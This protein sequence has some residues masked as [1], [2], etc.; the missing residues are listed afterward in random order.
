MFGVQ[1]SYPPTRRSRSPLLM[2]IVAILLFHAYASKGS[3]QAVELHPQ[4]PR[5]VHVVFF[6]G[7]TAKLAWTSAGAPKLE[8]VIEQS[9][10]G[11]IWTKPSFVQFKGTH[12]LIRNLDRSATWFFRVRAIN[13]AG[14]S[15]A[16]RPTLVEDSGPLAPG[17]SQRVTGTTTSSKKPGLISERDRFDIMTPTSSRP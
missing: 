3:N 16:S 15:P 11:E 17:N 9:T 4:A 14:R 2:T 6:D 5:N 8:F 12:A 7:K 13:S 10:D 1:S